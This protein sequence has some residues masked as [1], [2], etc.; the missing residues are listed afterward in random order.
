M[1]RLRKGRFRESGQRNDGGDSGDGD[2]DDDCIV[3]VSFKIELSFFYITHH[4]THAYPKPA[5]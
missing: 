2:D 1:V 5:I 4:L 3:K